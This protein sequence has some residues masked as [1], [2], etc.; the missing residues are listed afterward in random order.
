ME[1]TAKALSAILDGLHIGLAVADERGTIIVM[2]EK[3]GEMVQVNA[4]ERVGSPLALC[5][6]PEAMPN[7]DRLIA[8]LRNR[9]KDR[10][11]AW[12]NFKGRVI[13]EYLYGIWDREGR[14]V[15]I[16]DELHDAAERAEYLKLH[17]RWR[18]LPVSGVGARGPRPVKAETVS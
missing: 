17:G 1:L 7:V 2:N 15:G 12:V 18:E 16:A 13:Y 9:V 10:E 11:E 14:F 4:K 5:H 8:D 6:P 3:F